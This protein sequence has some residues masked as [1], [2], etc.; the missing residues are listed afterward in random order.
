[1]ENKINY[2]QNDSDKQFQ[3]NKTVLKQTLAEFKKVQYQNKI[4]RY[5]VESQNKETNR[6]TQAVFLV[7][8]SDPRLV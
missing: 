4:L 7:P 5:E 3:E 8:V 6:L 1:M 2:L